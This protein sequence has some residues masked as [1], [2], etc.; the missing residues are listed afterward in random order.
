MLQAEAEH[1]KPAP[2]VLTAQ[3]INVLVSEGPSG[4][5]F[6]LDE[7]SLRSVE[8]RDDDLIKEMHG[9]LR[10]WDHIRDQILKLPEVLRPSAEG[11]SANFLSSTLPFHGNR[12]SDRS[13][14]SNHMQSILSA[15]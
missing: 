5:Y 7:G 10:A 13:F 11:I 9:L 12:P 14:A 3:M 2:R 8:Q 4:T 6:E 1:L 15:K